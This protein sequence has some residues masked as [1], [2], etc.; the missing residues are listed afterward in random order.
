L[1][2]RDG[3]I[4]PHNKGFVSKENELKRIKKASVLIERSL[5]G[6]SL[7]YKV[8][9]FDKGAALSS[10]QHVVRAEEAGEAQH[11]IADDS[12]VLGRFGEG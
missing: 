5:I 10:P 7:E 8:K 2:N 1:G 9:L 6:K 11:G 12:K 3:F 4:N